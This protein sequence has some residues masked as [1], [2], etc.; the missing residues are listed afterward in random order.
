MKIVLK[1]KHKYFLLSLLTFVALMMF[2]YT[3]E[4]FRVLGA[5]LALLTSVAGSLWVQY[6]SVITKEDKR[7]EFFKKTILSTI[8]LPTVLVA[9]AILS[10]IYFPNLSWPVKTLAVFSVSLFM[11]VT[12]L[13]TNIFLVVFEKGEI[14]PLFRAASTWSQILIVV[15]AIPFFAGVFKLP[16]ISPFQ[17]AI[18]GISALLFALY[19]IWVQN[20][21]PDIP[22]VNRGEILLNAGFIGFLVTSMSIATSFI[23]AES[24]LRALLM[25]SFLMGGLGYMQAHYKNA[26]TKKLVIEF[27]V[28][29]TIF[30]LFVFFFK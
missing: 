13:S 18:I 7:L 8:T 5:I 19:M 27:A 6:S 21:D 28:I 4:S 29:S 22:Q 3:D 14:I 30:L 25:A 10:L 15:I 16:L 24:F 2:A 11:Y 17:S 20:M 1:R 26:I 23:P 12:S 9:G